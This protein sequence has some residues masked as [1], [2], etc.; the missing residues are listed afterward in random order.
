MDFFLKNVI[1]RC[2]ALLQRDILWKLFTYQLLLRLVFSGCGDSDRCVPL[3]LPF[4][5]N[6]DQILTSFNKQNNLSRVC[7]YQDIMTSLP[8]FRTPDMGRTE[9]SRF[10]IIGNYITLFS[11][12]FIVCQTFFIYPKSVTV[13]DWRCFRL[14]QC[15]NGDC[16]GGKYLYGRV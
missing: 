3:R 15:G 13:P 2:F 11:P 5:Q 9:M 16:V 4:G 12:M 7:E 6:K 10:S 8:N 14:F 1:I